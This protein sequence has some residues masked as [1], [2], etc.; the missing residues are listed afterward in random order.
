MKKVLFFVLTLSVVLFSCSSTYNMEKEKFIEGYLEKN[1]TF[2]IATCEDGF[3]NTEIYENSGRTVA[4]IIKQE[5]T[6]YSK[7][8][9]I[10]KK[11]EILD[12]FTAEE[13]ATNDYIVIPKILHWEDRATAWSGRP[14]KLEITITIYDSK[15]K[16]LASAN[17]SGK[18][19]SMTLGTTDPSE[20]LSKPLKEWLLTLFSE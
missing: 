20:L 11:N 4:N 10:Y 18:S 12:D 16:P 1:K 19:A 8:V 15:K 7:R 6:P 5:L 17:I 13:L 14:D 9:T 2:G 3:Y